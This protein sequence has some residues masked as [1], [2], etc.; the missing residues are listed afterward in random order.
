M[1][2]GFFTGVT[3]RTPDKGLSRQVKHRTLKTSFGDGYEQRLPDGINT[4]QESFNTS[5]NNR[6]KSEIVEISDFLDTS[7]STASSFSLTVPSLNGLS[8]ESILVV[9]EEFSV[10]YNYDNFYSLSA[11][12]RRVYE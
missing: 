3:L 4:L 2:L 6:D 11:V 5:F 8:E 10:T 1:A 7:S 12:L 9:C